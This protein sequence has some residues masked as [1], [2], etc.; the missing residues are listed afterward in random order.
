M[1]KLL[2]FR[3]YPPSSVLWILLVS[4]RQLAPWVYAAVLYNDPGATLTD[5]REAVTTLEDAGRIAR[6]VFGGA[7]PV[8]TGIEG[9]LRYA[10]AILRARERLGI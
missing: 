7:H 8:T 1:N 5:H 10:R 6:R 3:S 9:S 2:Y 4:Y